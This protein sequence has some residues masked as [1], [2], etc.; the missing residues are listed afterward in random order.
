[1]L[2]RAEVGAE[3][4]EGGGGPDAV[5]C[6]GRIGWSWCADAL[7]PDP[8]DRA[9]A[10][11]GPS[12]LVPD[13]S[14]SAVVGVKYDWNFFMVVVVVTIGPGRTR[15]RIALTRVSPGTPCHLGFNTTTSPGRMPGLWPSPR[16]RI[17]S[18][19]EAEGCRRAGNRV[20]SRVTEAEGKKKGQEP[21]VLEKIALMRLKAASGRGW[22]S[23]PDNTQTCRSPMDP[24]W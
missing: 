12:L 9:L 22:S 1:M 6:G 2:A 4:T 23:R 14:S 11:C 7:E 20:A 17:S 21:G 3:V 5:P 8:R 13:F 10:A 18:G 24:K 19:V 16:G 15:Q